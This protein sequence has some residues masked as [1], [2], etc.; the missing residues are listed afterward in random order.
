[1]MKKLLLILFFIVPSICFSQ[2]FSALQSKFN[3]NYSGKRISLEKNK[4]SRNFYKQFKVNHI[5][6]MAIYGNYIIFV[7][8]VHD[9]LN[10]LLFDINTTKKIADL[11]FD[12]GMLKNPHGNTLCFGTEF[13]DNTD[14]MPVLYL[15][16]WNFDGERGVLVYRIKK[17]DNVYSAELK[18]SILPDLSNMD[19]SKFGNGST[20]WVVDTDNNILYSI[21]YKL[22]GSSRIVIGNATMIC[23]FDLPKLSDGE[24]V[25][26]DS[27]NILDNYQLSIINVVQDKCYY[28]GYIYM[29]SGPSS[30]PEWKKISVLNL[31]TKK[32]DS[33][34]PLGKWQNEPECIVIFNNCIIQ[35]YNT[36]NI[37]QLSFK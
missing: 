23:K 21:A 22:K 29:L 33:V 34:V 27:S 17:T 37:Y 10:G 31:S 20:D 12:Y 9:K 18:Q 28:N 19:F 3:Y 5:Q 11:T 36:G 6:S 15:S 26:L 25:L 1:M 35:G 14:D 30:V 7:T 13:A 8:N 32:I 16:Q 2:E 4:F 24:K